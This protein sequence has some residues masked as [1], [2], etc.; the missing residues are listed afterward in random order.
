VTEAKPAG[1]QS[2]SPAEPSLGQ[3]EPEKGEEELEEE[4]LKPLPVPPEALE[5]L[6]A[7]GRQ[8]AIEEQ[9]AQGAQADEELLA[10][11]SEAAVQATYP[12]EDLIDTYIQ[13]RS[14]QEKLEALHESGEVSDQV[15]DRLSREYHDKLTRLDQQIR[16]ETATLR[17]Y[18]AQ[19]SSDLNQAQEALEALEVRIRIGDTE[20][21]PQKEHSQL[22]EQIQRLS[23]AIN[24]AKHILAKE[25]ALHGAA[26]PRFQ[27]TE[28]PTQPSEESSKET[29]EK[30]APQPQPE[31]GKIC[32]VCGFVAKPGSKYCPGC[33]GKL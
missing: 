29:E 18:L 23:H 2:T 26:P 28:T 7:R 30:P 5:A 4:E 17:R 10:G 20:G 11:L 8:L 27:I 12:L 9:Y 13:E 21:D 22:T 33:G 1:L 31:A 6:I 14:E 19:L 24:A 25:A 15:Y 32:P 16:E 3:P